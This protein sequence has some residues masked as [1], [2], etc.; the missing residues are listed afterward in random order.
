MVIGAASMLTGCGLS[1]IDFL[2][3]EVLQTLE[4]CVEKMHCCVEQP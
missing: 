3:I 4:G 1:A 2:A